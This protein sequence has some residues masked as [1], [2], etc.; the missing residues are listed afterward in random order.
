M[1]R[2]NKEKIPTLPTHVIDKTT[3]L[4]HQISGIS[5]SAALLP[6]EPLNIRLVTLGM[7]SAKNGCNSFERYS[8]PTIGKSIIGATFF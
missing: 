4:L 2:R 6:K 7:R 8:R 3:E 5:F 1:S